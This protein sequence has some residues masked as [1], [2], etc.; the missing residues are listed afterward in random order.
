MRQ[1]QFTAEDDPLK[2]P[3]TMNTKPFAQILHDHG[4]WPQHKHPP[5]SFFFSSSHPTPP[6]SLTT[7]AR[8][9]CTRTQSH[10]SHPHAHNHGIIHH[11][12]A[13]SPGQYTRAG[14]RASTD[15]PTDPTPTPPFPTRQ[16]RVAKVTGGAQSKLAK[17]KV[18]RKSIARVLTVYNQTQK[19]KLREVYAE[20]KYLPTD[21]RIKKTRA[22]RRQLKDDEKA[23]VTSKSQKKSWNFPQRRYAVKA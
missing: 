12:V 6:T 3:R 13:P 19:A 4:S 5:V 21:L 11:R 20:R 18:V 2:T 22:I 16:L 1:Q 15:P 10:F 7:T 9:G 8:P 17:I 14:A 23:K